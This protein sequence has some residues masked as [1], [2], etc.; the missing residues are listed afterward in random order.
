MSPAI[1]PARGMGQI[2]RSVARPTLARSVTDLVVVAELLGHARLETTR[3]Y[4]RAR[5]SPTSRRPSGPLSGG[6]EMQA[7]SPAA[8]AIFRSDTPS[9]FAL[10]IVHARQQPRLASPRPTPLLTA[11]RHARHEREDRAM[12]GRHVRKN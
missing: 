7:V 5:L 12:C 8:A 2:L 11:D 9:A 3:G 1:E 10:A 6:G 4:T